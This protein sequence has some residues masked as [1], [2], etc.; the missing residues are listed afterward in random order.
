MINQKK[1][2]NIFD[3]EAAARQKLSK[4]AYDYYASGVGD[5]ITLHLV[6]EPLGLEGLSSGVL[7]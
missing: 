3:F 2:V 4:V 7:Q 1:L 6:P 5:E